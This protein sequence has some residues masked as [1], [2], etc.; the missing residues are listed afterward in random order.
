MGANGCF[1]INVGV[2]IDSVF[3]QLHITMKLPVPDL[4]PLVVQVLILEVIQEKL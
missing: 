1:M 2:N 4:V 3:I